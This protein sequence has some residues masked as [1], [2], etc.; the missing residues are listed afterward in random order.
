MRTR[1]R[2]HRPRIEAL[3]DRRV[4]ATWGVP[5]AAPQQLTASFVPDGTSAQGQASTLYQT[6]D[7]QLGAGNWEPAILKALQ[8]WAVNS[9][10]NVGVVSDGGQ[11][12]GTPGPAQ[13]D[14]RFGDIRITAEPLPSDVVAITS[15]Y[16]PAYGTTSGDI[17]FNSNI[18]FKPGDSGSYDLFT[19]ALHEAG[20]VF[21]FAD[22]SDPSSFMYN[23]Y[24]GPQTALPSGAIPALQALYGGARNIDTLDNIPFST[25]PTKPVNIP[26]PPGNSTPVAV[27]GDLASAQQSN[28]FGFKGPSLTSDAAG[29][30]FAGP[31]LGD[32]PADP[33][34]DGARPPRQRRGHGRRLQPARRRESRSTS[35]GCSRGRTTRS[36]SR[37]PPVTCSPW[38][39]TT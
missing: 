17:I 23:V 29:R 30:R 3:E 34:G 5:W 19:V 28:Y 27:P 9:N 12:L 22:S 31:D 18:D 7:A 39:R 20:H 37:A 36:R 35:A 26:N 16:S 6:L 15:P 25:D 10:I 24:Q 2:R 21:G 4:P 14:A 8:T 1:R 11:P 13:G 38:A 32:Q 33:E